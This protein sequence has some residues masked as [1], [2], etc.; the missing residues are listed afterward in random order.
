MDFVAAPK[1]LGFHRRGSWAPSPVEGNGLPIFAAEFAAST[2]AATAITT[3]AMTTAAP[4]STAA[5]SATVS[6]V[7][8]ASSSTTAAAFATVTTAASSATTTVA[9]SS[10]TTS[11]VAAASS[12]AT[13]TAALFGFID[14]ER[15]TAHVLA[16]EFI[17]RGLT[18]LAAG[19]SDKCEAA[20]PARFAI[21]WVK[22]VG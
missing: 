19:E 13:A 12:A 14:T 4:S 16:I 22:E 10:A 3:V 20:L 1:G 6:A 9:A 21:D 17:Q 7:S 8:T 5:A 11:T 2:E 15:T 18:G